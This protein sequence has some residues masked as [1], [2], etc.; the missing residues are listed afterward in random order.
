M[1]PYRSHLFRLYFIIAIFAIGK[2][3]GCSK[4]SLP[5]PTTT[6]PPVIPPITTTTKLS[7][8]TISPLQG[9]PRALDTISGT[10]FNPL[11][12]GDSVFFNGVYAAV[13]SAASTQLV[14]HIPVTAT[15]GVIS[16]K[17]NGSMTGGPVYTVLAMPVITTI[18]PT[19]GQKGGMDTLTGSGFS[20]Q[21]SGNNISYNGYIAEVYAASPNQLIVKIPPSTSGPVSVFFDG[22]TSIGPVFTY[23]SLADDSV[24]VSTFAGSGTI[25]S[26]D[27]IGTAAS[28][29]VLYG[30]AADKSGNLFVADANN[31]VIRMITSEGVVT[32]VA[33]P[34]V[35]P[36]LYP[37]DTLLNSPQGVAVDDNGVLYVTN[38]IANQIVKIVNGVASTWAG[39]G[40]GLLLDGAP[41]TALFYYP[42]NLVTD[43]NGNV[44]VA[45][46]MNNSIRK[47]TPDGRVSTLADDLFDPWG[48]TIDA[49]GNLYVGNGYS[50]IQKI[51]PDGTVTTL[52][53]HVYGGDNDGVGAAAGFTSV[54][55]IATDANGNMYFTDFANQKIKMLTPS[56]VVTT[57]AGTGV[58]GSQDGPGNQATFNEPIGIAVAND[59]TIYVADGL[60]NKVRKIVITHHH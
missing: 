53:G 50:E 15:T 13:V 49:N 54:N 56:G 1:T 32:T 31:N 51:T 20:S 43:Q 23:D 33:G 17:V 2:L 9:P 45:D 47:I 6:V 58:R 28:F 59:G 41:D 26:Q 14:V 7:I 60:N 57:I 16:V 5:D 4:A 55:G 44:F 39:R 42:R 18:S 3:A 27:G 12:T 37:D 38:T 34:K 8:V 24:M 10:G 36:L 22:V 25:G 35:K 29:S 19:H 40:A 46:F 52:A 30:L 11:A 21:V 48:L